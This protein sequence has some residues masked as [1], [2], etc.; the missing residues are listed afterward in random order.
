[1]SIKRGHPLSDIRSPRAQHFGSEPTTRF[2]RCTAEPGSLC[3]LSPDSTWSSAVSRTVLFIKDPVYCPLGRL[4]LCWTWPY[5]RA[6]QFDATKLA[7]EQWYYCMQMVNDTLMPCKCTTTASP[8][9]L[10]CEIVGLGAPLCHRTLYEHQGP[11]A[12]M[13]LQRP[14]GSTNPTAFP[15]SLVWGKRETSSEFSTPHNLQSRM[16][17]AKRAPHLDQSLND[18]QGN[19][20]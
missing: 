6:A 4:T 20:W 17:R 10:V 2:Q 11:S 5:M 19:C 9:Y 8:R 13:L 1:M 7:V 12:Q 18:R 16:F 3:K 14:P 15:S